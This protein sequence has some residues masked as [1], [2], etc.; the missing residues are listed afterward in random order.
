M[1]ER[2]ILFSAPMVRAIL[3]GR[4]TQ[5]RILIKPQPRMGILTDG[6][7]A[8]GCPQE[9]G[10]IHHSRGDELTTRDC[11]HGQVGDMLWVREACR[12]SIPPSGSKHG[13]VVRYKADGYGPP[14]N[15]WTCFDYTS[16]FM[17]RAMARIR[18][19]VTGLRIEALQN[20]SAQD[21]SA[22][23]HHH[24]D[25]R[26]DQWGMPTELFVDARDEF[27]HHWEIKH[28]GI[29]SAWENNPWVWVIEFRKP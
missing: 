9:Y 26:P 22:E 7:A 12:I 13:K 25:G 21:A 16:G 24:S 20:I 3:D 14:F 5:H 19:E 1:T 4:K 17:P 15:H 28:A 11:I 27:R 18:L 6:A 23:G 29:A 2:P 10:L 8:T